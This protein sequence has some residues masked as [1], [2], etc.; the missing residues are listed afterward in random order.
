MFIIIP[1]VRAQTQPSK[2]PKERKSITLNQVMEI[3]YGSGKWNQESTK[4]DSAT[5]VFRDANS[6]KAVL[7]IVDETAP[8]SSVFKGKYSIGWADAD[9][10]VPEI[11]IPPQSLVKQNNWYQKFQTMI[12]KGELKRKP[13]IT[14][15]SDVVRTLDVFDTKE[16]A[17][18]AQKAIAEQKKYAEEA[19]QAAKP[20]PQLEKS[21]KTAAAVLEAEK[22]AQAAALAAQL[23]EAAANR[24]AERARLA[25]LEAQREEERK[26]KQLEL[27]AAEK[28]RRQDQAAKLAAEA[29]EHFKQGEFAD[30]EAKFKKSVELDPTNT[31]YYYKYG[32]T[33]YRNNK[34]NDSIVILTRCP[35]GTYDPLELDY[36]LALNYYQ[37]KE[38]GK[39]LEKFRGVKK[40]KHATL[41]PSAAFYEGLI[42]FGELK[43]EQA[44][45]AFQEVLDTSNDPKLDEQA[46]R[47]LEQIAGILHF[48]AQRAKTILLS[49]SLGLQNDTNILLL[50]DSTLDQGAA[51]GAGGLRYLFQGSA[52]YRPI[53]EKEK[54]FSVKLSTLLLYSAD[55]DFTTADP[56]ISNLSFPFVYKG[57][58]SGKGNK[59]EF[60]PAYETLNMNVDGV[61]SPENILNSVIVGIN[62]TTVLDE[63][64]FSSVALNI[65]QDTSPTT[66][67]STAMKTA[68]STNQLR[69]I[70]K[71]RTR[72]YNYELGYTVNNSQGDDYFY[73]RYDAKIGYT[74]PW[75]KD[76]VWFNQLAYYIANYAKK[77]PAETVKNMTLTTGLSKKLNDFFTAGGTISYT[78]QDSSV[79]TSDY[80]KWVAMLT[81]TGNY[82]F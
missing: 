43:Y 55:S 67:D 10:V 1:C 18:E 40:T 78:M 70:D 69:F 45:P 4:I 63:K 33:L 42:L 74:R 8:D 64:R 32:V 15:K 9:K 54:E 60:T 19:E 58:L 28:K 24:E 52:A 73:S 5:V 47:Y 65:R 62:N 38:N 21:L 80:S 44:R 61:G 17:Q 59:L 31:S 82:D 46:E 72:M 26:R 30:A 20:N 51:T 79:D 50:S 36:Y 49:A 35:P 76:A 68:I 13:F 37:L 48:A 39:A 53:Y 14:R 12:D 27:D 71:E 3:T 41:S 25:Q 2:K 56:V 34:F 75:I 66:E 16:Q 57:A 7:I 23:A 29:L 22:L 6:N 81:L 77:D 11:Y